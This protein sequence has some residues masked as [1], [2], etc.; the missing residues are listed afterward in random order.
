MAAARPENGS[1]Q[2][3]TTLQSMQR[4]KPPHQP[5]PPSASP[6]VANRYPTI[7]LNARKQ[8][9]RSPVPHVVRRLAPA[10]PR[11]HVPAV[12]TV[13]TGNSNTGAVLISADNLRR[14]VYAT[15]PSVSLHGSTGCGNGLTNTIV[16]FAGKQAITIPVQSPNELVSVVRPT[17]PTPPATIYKLMN[18]NSGPAGR[19]RMPQLAPKPAV[20]NGE[21]TLP[22]AQPQLQHEPKPIVSAANGVTGRGST[23]QYNN[24]PGWRRIL[25]NKVIV[26]ISPSNIVLHNYEQVKEYLLSSGTCKCGLPCPF[27]PEHFFQFDAQIPNMTMASKNREV[28]CAHI[29]RALT[30]PERSKR[31]HEETTPSECAQLPSAVQSAVLLK[32]P[33]WRKNVPMTASSPQAT[34]V[35]EIALNAMPMAR[36]S[37]QSDVI[38]TPYAGSPSDANANESAR[39]SPEQKKPTFKDDPTG[40]LNQ[41]TAI[42]HSSISFL[43]S[44][45]RRSPLPLVGELSPKLGETSPVAKP[46]PPK[47]DRSAIM[48]RQRTV[49]RTIP[50]LGG[51]QPTI[52]PQ[53]KITSLTGVVKYE[54]KPPNVSTKSSPAS[55]SSIK[56]AGTL[57]ATKSPLPIARLATGERGRMA[58]YVK[59]NNV[60]RT[61]HGTDQCSSPK[62][63]KLHLSPTGETLPCPITT[64]TTMT[65]TTIARTNPITTPTTTGTMFVPTRSSHVINAGGAQIVVIDGLQHSA[66]GTGTELAG[67]VRIGGFPAAR[68]Q[69]QTP[70]MMPTVS[71]PAHQQPTVVNYSLARAPN[72]TAPVP[73]PVSALSSTPMPTTTTGAM[74]LNGTNIIHLSNGLSA[75][76]FHGGL[77]APESSNPAGTNPCLHQVSP[78]VPSAG[79]T[80]LTLPNGTLGLATGSTVVLNPT[81]S[82]RFADNT[83]FTT[84]G[85][86]STATV[87]SNTYHYSPCTTVQGTDTVSLDVTGARKMK[88]QLKTLNG[89]TSGL[90]S[91]LVLPATPVAT[92]SQ[93]QPATFQQQLQPGPFV[94]IASPYGGL[95]NIQLASSLSGITV[96]PVSKATPL[97]QQHQ[98]HQQQHHQ[99]PY[100]LL[101][102]TQTILLPAGSM[103]MASD[104]NT[105]TATLLQIQNMTPCGGNAPLLAG[106]TGLVLRHQKPPSTAGF[107]STVGQQSYLIG[108]N[109]TTGTT[110]TPAVAQRCPGT[111]LFGNG[112]SLGIVTATQTLPVANLT[113]Q[114]QPQQ[115]SLAPSTT[116]NRTENAPHTPTKLVDGVPSHLTSTVLLHPDVT[117]SHS[118]QPECS[119]ENGNETKPSSR[120]GATGRTELK[121]NCV[122]ITETEVPGIAFTLKGPLL[123]EQQRKQQVAGPLAESSNRTG[124]IV[125]PA[126]V[127]RAASIG[128]V[129]RGP[130]VQAVSKQDRGK[131]SIAIPPTT[132]EGSTCLLTDVRPEQS[133]DGNAALNQKTSSK[134]R[135]K[136]RLLRGQSDPDELMSDE[137]R[138]QQRAGARQF[139]VGDLVWGAVRGFPAWPGKVLPAPAPT[140]NDVQ[141]GLQVTPAGEDTVVPTA[142]DAQ[143]QAHVWVRWFGTG[144][145]SAERVEVDTLQSLSE[146]LEIHH[147]AQKDARKSRKL[148]AQLEQ[149]IQQAMQE[150]DHA[151]TSPGFSPRGSVLEKQRRRRH[152]RR[153]TTCKRHRTVGASEGNSTG[154]VTSNMCNR[155]GASVRYL[156]G[157]KF[158]AKS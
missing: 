48:R 65:T 141:E 157:N 130:S 154:S 137:A 98:P 108:A 129:R 146:G 122:S 17:V 66:V 13:L 33:P 55:A 124:R 101:G 105:A 153:Q 152:Q 76:A 50:M 111:A 52:E 27:N 99:Q 39:E 116:T 54:T 90:G 89:T 59:A 80:S 21:Q 2:D 73:V 71:K 128:F 143:M 30:G 46:S 96:V 14:T 69:Q 113:M 10:Q 140:I 148:N 23:V 135:T 84:P 83:S 28:L 86:F 121:P 100:G 12:P 51:T 110:R 19:K 67:R 15:V 7:F 94:Q 6:S 24:A 107:I 106:Q 126:S 53:A 41:Q 81:T 61:P 155:K 68:H 134:S 25:R 87:A 132:P 37:K 149:A 138:E 9:A 18:A 136:R 77:L 117:P 133:Y 57:N 44:P 75:S 139:R 127:N 109:G 22:A 34:P 97:V 95:Q 125:S 36:L 8:V 123:A 58:Y 156:R 120:D 45:D 131:L 85:G 60:T 78:T 56:S 70:A 158:K 119:E 151:A 63:P 147:R 112:G 72:G 93:Q 49:N 31:L 92:L 38:S 114:Q 1:K 91:G 103:V 104:A 42:L 82:I 4:P 43:H 142:P 88:R 3:S 32:T 11:R 144:R 62:V 150:L 5:A 47:E 79:K 115:L 26:Y 64:T 102:Q 145:A 35:P 20:K 40:Y 74:L 16:S 118:N 29:Q